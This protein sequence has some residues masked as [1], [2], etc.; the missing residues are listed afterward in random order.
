MAGF[1][2]LVRARLKPAYPDADTAFTLVHTTY[3]DSPTLLSFSDYI[4]QRPVRF[5]VRIRQYAPN[6]VWQNPCVSFAEIKRSENGVSKKERFQ[7]SSNGLR[8]LLQ[9]DAVTLTPDE[10]ALNRSIGKE[11]LAQRI[12]L[13]NGLMSHHR[14]RPMVTVSYRRTAYEDGT[15]RVTVDTNLAWE[16]LV[17]P[18]P[19]LAEL[20]SQERSWVYVE[21]MEQDYRRISGSIVEVK[22]RECL[23]DWLIQYMEDNQLVERSFSKY[24]WSQTQSLRRVLG[25]VARE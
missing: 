19:T 5:K 21:K 10:E 2:A 22:H 24:C 7:L 14:L 15:M 17:A 18:P 6:G 1:D 23:P 12:E 4:N 20:M 13:L 8:T 25:E 11:R 3:F 16:A 9:G